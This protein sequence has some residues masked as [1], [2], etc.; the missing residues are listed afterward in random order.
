MFNSKNLRITTLSVLAG[1]NAPAAVAQDEA[2]SSSL[3]TQ[4]LSEAAM[5]PL[6]D[7]YHKSDSSLFLLQSTR[8]LL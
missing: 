7:S 6:T 1:L 3:P 4:P 5:P 2:S 8:I